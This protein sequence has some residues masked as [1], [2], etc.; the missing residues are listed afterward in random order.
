MMKFI[1]HDRQYST[2]IHTI[3]IIK[4]GVKTYAKNTVKITTQ[5]LI[6]I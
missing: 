5:T 2:Y 3:Q 4:E 1:R 6:P